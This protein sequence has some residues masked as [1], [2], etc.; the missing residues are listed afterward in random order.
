MTIQHCVKCDKKGE[1][2]LYE[3]CDCYENQYLCTECF[4]QIDEKLQENWCQVCQRYTRYRKQNVILSQRTQRIKTTL[5]YMFYILVCLFM[6]TGFNYYGAGS[7]FKSDKPLIFLGFCGYVATLLIWILL[8]FVSIL[9]GDIRGCINDTIKAVFEIIPYISGDKLFQLYQ[10]RGF[11]F[12]CTVICQVFGNFFHFYFIRSLLLKFTLVTFG[13]GVLFFLVIVLFAGIIRGLHQ[14]VKYLFSRLGEFDFVYKLIRTPI[15]L[16]VNCF[17]IIGW[18]YQHIEFGDDEKG[19]TKDIPITSVIV[20]WYIMLSFCFGCVTLFIMFVLKVID[21]V[22]YMDYLEKR[23][24]DPE[25]TYPVEKYNRYYP[26]TLFNIFCQVTGSLVSI[27]AKDKHAPNQWNILSYFFGMGMPIGAVASIVAFVIFIILLWLVFV[28]LPMK[29][30]E[31][32]K[33]GICCP[34]KTV[35]SKIENQ[36]KYIPLV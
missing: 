26:V 21:F 18:N 4:S 22:A 31:Y 2:L 12:V 34:S 7:H 25:E 35:I 29:I 13:W 28:F 9:I 14:L 33:Y 8:L 36:K 16:I 19:L 1:D 3:V 15:S 23:K 27:C 5:W 11:V 6:M 17:I 32:F 24:T 10:K 30:W 20:N